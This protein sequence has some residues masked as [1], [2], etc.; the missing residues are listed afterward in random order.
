MSGRHENALL[1][2]PPGGGVARIVFAASV[3]SRTSPRPA[4]TSRFA[5]STLVGRTC[6][7]GCAH[8]AGQ[9]ADERAL[10]VDAC[11]HIANQLVL[12]VE[13]R[14]P[15]DSRSHPVEPIGDDGG[16]HPAATVA[17]TASQACRIASRLR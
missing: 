7:C 9:R 11:H 8:K 10:H 5:T 1:G 13:C 3:T 6:S 16:E 2:K 14:E 15:V 12:S 17:R 4:S